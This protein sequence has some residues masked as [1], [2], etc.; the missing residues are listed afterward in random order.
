MDRTNRGV[1]QRRELK[2]WRV[3]AVA[4]VLLAVAIPAHAARFKCAGGDVQCLIAA[5]N[6]ANANGHKNTIWL[7]PG[8]YA[9]RAS[10]T[11]RMDRMVFR[12][13]PVTSRFSGQAPRRRASH[14][15]PVSFVS[16]HACGTER[17]SDT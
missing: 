10:I 7:A 9:L 3:L 2:M 17:P 6:E 14:P 12:L 4:T 15:H 13:L 11:T 8:T 16:V 1:A 5:I